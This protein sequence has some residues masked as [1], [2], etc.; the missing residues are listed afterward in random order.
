M[1]LVL[2]ITGRVGGAVARHLVREGHAVRAMVR[3]PLKAVEWSKRGVEIRKGDFNDASALAACLAGVHGAF[4]MLPPLLAPRPGFPEARATIGSFERALQGACP[5]R[6]VVLSSIGSEQR[7]GLGLITTTHLLEEALRELP[8]PTAFV[9]AGSFLDNYATA[10][11]M[12]GRSG[13][14]DTFRT[15]TSRAVPMVAT[16][17]IGKH[18]ARLLGGAW[19]GR[20]IIELG[21]PVSADD[22]ARAMSEV[23]GRAVTARSIPREQWA[24]TL[25]AQGTAPGTT[26]PFEEMEEGFNSGWIAFGVSGTEAVPA[27]IA[28]TGVFRSATK[29]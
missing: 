7:S 5:G 16:E 18:V 28:P 2:G 21:S 29:R 20:R 26:S 23:L 1:I 12:V 15:P 19:S 24:S 22:L 8:C 14:F 6:V 10:L 4:L 17:D 3:D 13:L 25:Q 11:D 27:E 9:R